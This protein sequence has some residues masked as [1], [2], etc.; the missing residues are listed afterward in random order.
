[1]FLMIILL[2]E[3]IGLIFNSE[4][5]LDEDDSGQLEIVN[6][7]RNLTDLIGRVPSDMEGRILYAVK[8]DDV[9]FFLSEHPAATVPNAKAVNGALKARLAVRLGQDI[10]RIRLAHFDDLPLGDVFAHLGK[11]SLPS[12]DRS[13]IETTDGE[14]EEMFGSRWLGHALSVPLVDG[15]WLNVFLSR[16]SEID[17]TFEE[18]VGA[19]VFI[20]LL[21][22]VSLLLMRRFR[23]PVKEL[24]AAAEQIG[25]GG[26]VA[27]LTETGPE[28]IRALIRTFNRM[29]KRLS[30]YLDDNR[31]MLAAL[32][33]DLRTPITAMR[34]RAEL[35]DDR[36]TR[37]K[38]ILSLEDMQNMTE[39][40]LSFVQE[41]AEQEGSR[42]VDLPTLV[43]S[44]CNDYSDQGRNVSFC[45]MVS[46][47][48]SCRPS[49]LKRAIDNLIGNAVS[50]ADR[51]QVTLAVESDRAIIAIDDDGPGIPEDKL[52][53]V[54]GPFKRLD[55]ARSNRTGGLGLGL[56]I[57]RTII[58]RHGG[59]LQLENRLGAGLRATVTLP[60]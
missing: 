47:A 48:M 38:I 31:Q 43:E 2:P 14:I 16:Q 49:S 28:S 45:G 52:T 59:E 30:R 32:G 23:R 12:V 29:N 55:E 35:I 25:R 40:L 17:D 37:D 58:R 27:P 15:R 56:P 57:A 26:A 34:V 11:Y 44:I 1:M 21:V 5:Y 4:T 53:T 3:D 19:I 22:V 24:T 6:Q 60:L 13:P 33:H 51:V 18:S 50:Y 41:N 36:E 42:L 54:F 9:W 20:L 46:L 10:S 7:V 8:L 39:S